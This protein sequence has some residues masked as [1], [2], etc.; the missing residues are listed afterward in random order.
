MP[1]DNIEPEILGFVD[2]Y[3]EQF[4]CWDVFAYFHENP[5]IEKQSSDIAIDV[6][7]RATAIEPVLERFVEQGV[8]SRDTEE[9]EEPM[10]R[11]KAPAGVRHEMDAFLAA[12]R[13]RTTR[14]AIVSK[15]LQR[16]ARRL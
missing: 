7:R 5:D 1:L 12:T 4:A 14:L 11:Y 9:G 3:I 10:Y 13:D 16:E 8:L 6:G 2:Q 15:V